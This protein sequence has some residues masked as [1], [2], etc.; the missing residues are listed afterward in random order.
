MIQIAVVIATVLHIPSLLKRMR[1]VTQMYKEEQSKPKP[2]FSKDVAV[3]DIEDPQQIQ[4]SSPISEPQQIQEP[5]P[6]FSIDDYMIND[7]LEVPINA[8]LVNMRL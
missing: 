1:H 2:E 5:E 3:I 6:I 7:W 8:P 4:I